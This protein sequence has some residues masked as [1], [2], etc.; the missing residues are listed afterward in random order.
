MNNPCSRTNLGI[1]VL[2]YVTHNE[3]DE[4]A[5]LLEKAEEI[6]DVCSTLVIGFLWL[7][8]LMF[9]QFRLHIPVRNDEGCPCCRGKGAGRRARARTQAAGGAGRE[10]R[11]GSAAE[12]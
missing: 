12:D 6:D 7:V 4:P 9:F 10:G 1:L 3:I 5:S 2:G 8:F 11:R